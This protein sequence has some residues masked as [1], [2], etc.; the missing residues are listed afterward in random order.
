M[1]AR[2]LCTLLLA[3]CGSLVPS[4]R[5]AADEGETPDLKPLHAA[6]QKLV[7]KHYPK[8][9]VTLADGKIHFEYKT[10]TF[11]IHEPTL[12]GEWQDAHEELGPNKGGIVGDIQ[13]QP[14]PYMGM[15]AVPQT[16]DKRYYM[17]LLTA[18]SSKG[19]VAH[20][21]VNLKYPRNAPEEFVKEFK[22]LVDE[23]EKY[24]P[25]P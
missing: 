19:L 3:A 12:L 4:L 23:F 21:W 1:P 25:S 10:R 15:A 6:V 24:V 17:L 11:L 8:A 20:L 22:E 16:F 9:E 5:L 14:G 2:L 13:Y 18:P 7:I